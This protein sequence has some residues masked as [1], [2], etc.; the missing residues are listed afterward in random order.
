LGRGGAGVIRAR[1]AADLAADPDPLA[2]DAR[3]RVIDLRDE[4]A[5]GEVVAWESNGRQHT[6][7]AQREVW[8]G[9][10]FPTV[11]ERVECEVPPDWAIRAML[12]A[13]GAV[14]ETTA[15]G[16]AVWELGGLPGS[17]DEDDAPPYEERLPRLLLSIRAPDP[18]PGWA[19]FQQ[20]GDVSV[21]LDR[22]REPSSVADPDLVSRARGL[23]AGARTEFDS[24]AAIARLVQGVHY[25]SI[26]LRLADGGGFTPR[27]ASHVLAESYGDCKDKANLMC[28]MLGA[29]GLDAR[30]LAV[31]FSAPG[32]VEPKWPSPMVFDHCIVGVRC[33]EATDLPC[34]VRSG[35]G[36]DYLVFDPTDPYTVLGDLPSAEQG[37]RAVM[38]GP[39]EDS[40]V[41]LPRLPRDSRRV[42]RQVD[43]HLDED[44]VLR[45]VA[46]IV[47]SGQAAATMRALQESNPAE[48]RRRVEL[49]V[50]ASSEGGAIDSF[51]VHDDP[52]SGRFERGFAFTL[53][54]AGRRPSERLMTLRLSWSP[55]PG[56][57]RPK[58]RPR[59]QPM[60][61]HECSVRE[62][63]TVAVPDGWAIDEMPRPV[64]HRTGWGAFTS[65]SAIADGRLQVVRSL[66]IERYRLP[67]ARMDEWRRFAADVTAAS[68]ASA[69]LVLR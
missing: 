27:A 9:G 15:V 63:L 33:R 30:M 17:P 35:S 42:T 47:A 32:S 39:G 21:W 48:A 61:L 16:G 22:L 60:D 57:V 68:A 67:A 1:D 23:V 18:P 65:T 36:R 53:P 20:W 50:A 45:G 38:I 44:G 28:V 7:F 51:G 69:V 56:V 13:D 11:R 8:L 26:A 62:T 41:T 2:S 55:L 25:V 6:V 3:V 43:A 52:S 37:A 31:D 64:E 40:L 54:R 29:I 5:P 19:V 4:V 10:Y 46:R 24:V 49:E 59:R 66:E 12:V 34:H 58:D 14:R